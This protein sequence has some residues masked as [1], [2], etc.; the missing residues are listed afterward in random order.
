ME[1][2]GIDAMYPETE[3]EYNKFEEALKTKISFFE[4]RN[5]KMMYFWNT[6]L[7]I[8]SPSLEFIYLI[9]FFISE[10]QKLCSIFRKVIHRFSGFM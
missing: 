1:S 5:K 4:V 8:I 2:T 10:I 7:L 9:F 3:E 6:S